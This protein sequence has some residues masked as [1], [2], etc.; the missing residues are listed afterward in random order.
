M[1]DRAQLA[2]YI[3]AVLRDEP[4]GLACATIARRLSV[5]DADVRATLRAD[6][7]FVQ[8]G[9]TRGSRWHLVAPDGMGR[10][11][12]ESEQP[13]VLEDVLRRI[14]ALEARVDALGR[15]NGARA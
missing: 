2:A 7:W 5:R 6:P 8:Y 14:E 1:T 15:Q 10:N 4:D 12:T 9:S 3:A 13:G 11:G